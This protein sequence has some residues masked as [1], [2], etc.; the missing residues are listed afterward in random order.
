MHCKCQSYAILSLCLTSTVPAHSFTRIEVHSRLPFKCR[1]ISRPAASS[2]R[3]TKFWLIYCWVCLAQQPVK[4]PARVSGCEWLLS[5]ARCCYAGVDWS[6]P[7]QHQQPQWP[8]LGWAEPLLASQVPESPALSKQLEHAFV[9][10]MCMSPCK[11][12]F[13]N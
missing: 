4:L 13:P 10:Q 7:A 6:A 9:Q 3:I 1:R 12:S 11:S 2:S 8:R 5:L